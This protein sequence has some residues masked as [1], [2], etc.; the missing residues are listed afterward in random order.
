M[1]SVVPA[2]IYL[3]VNSLKHF[4][5]F[6]FFLSRISLHVF[7]SPSPVSN[8][9][10]PQL[11][12]YFLCLHSEMVLSCSLSSFFSIDAFQIA[13][14]VA[15]LRCFCL[16]AFDHTIDLK[17]FTGKKN[18]QRLL[19]WRKLNTTFFLMV[20]HLRLAE[21]HFMLIITLCHSVATN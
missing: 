3:P 15:G 7:L 21:M 6:V 19:T 10:L 5:H 17:I 16:V 2:Y 11:I 13:H 18:F 1:E 20:Y 14:S 12:S 4:S 8:K 9:T